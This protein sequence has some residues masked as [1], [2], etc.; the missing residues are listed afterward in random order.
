MVHRT[1]P[2][3]G[4]QR[5]DVRRVSAQRTPL[6]GGDRG[7]IEAKIDSHDV[8]TGTWNKRIQT[9]GQRLDFTAGFGVQ[10]TQTVLAKKDATTLLSMGKSMIAAAEETVALEEPCADESLH[11]TG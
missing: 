3:L 7:T 6:V 8:R 11:P 9:A 10:S 4:G 2:H 5:S 1:S